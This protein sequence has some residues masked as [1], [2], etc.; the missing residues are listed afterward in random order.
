MAKLQLPDSLVN[1][2]WLRQHLDDDDLVILDSSWHMPQTGRDA[3]KEWQQ[4]H[5]RGARFFDFDG[6]IS[7]PDSDLPHM[8]PNEELF[9]REMQALGLDQD[10]VV[11]VYDAMGMFSS[12]RGWW[13][14][15]A[16][17]CENCALLDGGLVA[18][19]E[20]EFPIESL[21]REPAYPPGNFVARLDKRMVADASEVLA[22]LDD[23]SLCVIDARP[24]P[25]FSGAAEEPRPGLRRG[26]MPRAV[27]LPFPDLFKHG[28]LKPADELEAM[29]A[30]L[31]GDSTRSI[32][33]CGSGVTACITA[34]AAQR[35]GYDD[36]AVYD[37]S[38]SEWGRPGDLPVVTD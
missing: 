34:F 12:P 23:A 8:L 20:A 17:G 31:I 10:S 22:A 21:Q 38:W 11:V 33:S 1:V 36:F 7:D 15:R 32:H 4:E 3:F 28:L 30:P 35:V 16:M 13:M 37:G 5:I 19:N 25:R 14:L 6:K 29:I 2:D 24:G 27:N 18:W 9:T 26:H